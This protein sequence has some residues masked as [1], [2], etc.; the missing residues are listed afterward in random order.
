[1]VFGFAV[2]NWVN[3]RFTYI[4]NNEISR[5]FSLGFQCALALSTAAFVP[6]L[7]ESPRWLYL[8]GREEEA[9]VIIARIYTKPLHEEEVYA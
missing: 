1:M 4:D 8:K 2:T 5:R 7:V 9:R 3:L 6:L